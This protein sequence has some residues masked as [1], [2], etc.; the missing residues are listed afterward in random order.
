MELFTSLGEKLYNDMN[1]KMRSSTLSSA[2][3]FYND[4]NIDKQISD[5]DTKISELETRLASV[6]ARY[7]KQ[8]TAMEQA[9][10]QS[11]STSNWLT[12]QLGGL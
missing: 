10:Q 6:E 5:F 11:N 9:M 12:Q 3:T 4:K 1:I 7:Y 2:L 8:F